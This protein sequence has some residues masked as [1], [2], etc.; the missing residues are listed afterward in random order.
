MFKI[1]VR[2]FNKTLA[3]DWLAVLSPIS[4]ILAFVSI[5]I[6]IPDR[7]K[8]PTAVTIFFFFIVLYIALW[9]RANLLNKTGLTINN[10]TVEIKVGDIFAEPGLKVIAFNEYFDTQVDNIIISDSTL[11]GMYIKRK[12]LDVEKLDCLIEQN[13]HLNDSKIEC[14]QNRKRGKKDK[15]KLGTIYQNNDYLLTAFSKFDN[16]NRAFLYM[17]DYVNFLLNFWNE[18]DIVYN[19]R[20]IAI[21]LLGTGIT[22]FKGYDMITD[23]E[24]LELLIWSFKISK[25]KFTHP[26]AV[27]IIIHESK[28]DK[29]D[30]YKLKELV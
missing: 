17:N 13:E 23:Q 24:L 8:L 29:I 7:Y 4:V 9:V 2:F 16:N 6:S 12:I 11:N 25:I 28:K 3:K 15:Y 20:S 14:N 21:P 18:V 19:G 10:S 1:K 26:S 27:S 5:T 22:R 30:F